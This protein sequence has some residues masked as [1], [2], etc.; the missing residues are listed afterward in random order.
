M[1]I[2]AGNRTRFAWVTTLKFKIVVMAA[3]TGVLS[4]VATAELLLSA[5]EKNIR[6]V[7]MQA[8]IDD[9]QRT[10]ELLAT[11]LEILQSA[12]GAVAGQVRPQMWSQPEPCPGTWQTS[13]HWVCCLTTCLLRAPA[14]KCLPAW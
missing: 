4:A 8:D 9:V 10:A 13:R 5:T 2:A 7:L 11:K 6:S 14:V 3:V 12:L 1:T